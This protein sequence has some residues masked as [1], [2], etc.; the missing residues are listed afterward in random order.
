MDPGEHKAVFGLRG[1][2]AARRVS[3]EPVETRR[4]QR[5]LCRLHEGQAESV[6]QEM[7]RDAVTYAAGRE[8][9]VVKDYLTTGVACGRGIRHETSRPAPVD[10][11]DVMLYILIDTNRLGG[12]R[13]AAARK[14]NAPYTRCSPPV[15][16]LSL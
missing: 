7:E 5:P 10:V 16:S 3:P 14:C 11:R 12:L 2:K 4:A 6:S 9:S 15:A 13:L 1:R 8:V